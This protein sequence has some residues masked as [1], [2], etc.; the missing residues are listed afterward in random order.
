MFSPLLQGLMLGASMII[1]IGAQNSHLLNHGIKRNHHILAA[2]ICLC[3]DV[4]LITFGIFGGAQLIA[5]S[6]LLMMLI[7]WGGVLFLFSYAALSFRNVWQNKYQAEQFHTKTSNRVGVI[8]TTLAVTLL[9]PHVY[10]DTVVILGGVGGQFIGH[11]KVAFAIGTILASII[12][13]YSITG[14]AAKLAPWLNR[15]QT[16]RAID[17]LVGIIMAAIAY[18][19]LTNL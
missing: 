3:C 1:P 8:S 2:T 12:W 15:P 18:S 10:L 9:N 16:K 6:A 7:S 5:S 14:T 4:L 11:E 13:F 17:A 19:L